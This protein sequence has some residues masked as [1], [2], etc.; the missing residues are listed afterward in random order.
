ML[1]YLLDAIERLIDFLVSLE[2]EGDGD[3]AHGEDACILGTLSDDGC[4]TGACATTHSGGYEDHACAIVEHL[5]DVLEAFHGCGACLL[6][7]VACSEAVLAKLQM[8]GYGRVLQCL[9]IGVADDVCHVVDS[10]AIHVVHGVAPSTSHTHYL[11]D[12]GRSALVRDVE[13]DTAGL[14]HAALRLRLAGGAGGQVE[15][16]PSAIEYGILHSIGVYS[17]F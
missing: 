16:K 13:C 6:G 10:F 1:G 9:L 14:G 15:I 7:Y 11:D 8:I 12:A 17:G 3:N 5:F 2:L 4:R